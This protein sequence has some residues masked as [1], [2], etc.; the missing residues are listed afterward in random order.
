MHI[1]MHIQNAP[2]LCLSFLS[3]F[4][5]LMPSLST[6]PPLY[7]KARS[8]LEKMLHDAEFVSAE[9]VLSLL[10]TYSSADL[11]SIIKHCISLISVSN[12]GLCHRMRVW[13]LCLLRERERGREGE[14]ERERAICPHIF[15]LFLIIGCLPFILLSPSPSPSPPP[16]PSPSL[17]LLSPPEEG[18]VLHILTQMCKHQ[19]DIASIIKVE[20]SSQVVTTVDNSSA[21]PDEGEARGKEGRSAGAE[22]DGAAVSGEVGAQVSGHGGGGGGDTARDLE[23]IEA[24]KTAARSVWHGVLRVKAPG[25]L[26]ALHQ[27][28]CV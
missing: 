11:L 27:V 15:L 13:I 4:L 6:P 16:S 8:A 3:S 17:P 2:V 5:F 25:I 21:Q 24:K 9:R 19:L 28:V 1:Y 18:S 26:D 20:H 14:R 7:L 10:S 22:G 23:I 12:D